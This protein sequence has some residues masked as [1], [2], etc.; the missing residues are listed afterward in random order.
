VALDLAGE[1]FVHG[2][3]P[4][5]FSEDETFDHNLLPRLAAGRTADG[6]T[7]FA[8]IDGRNFARALGMTL[9]QT[10]ALLRELGCTT[11]VNLDGGSSKRMVVRGRAVDLATT[12]VVSGGAPSAEAPV[13]PVF[14]ALL[15]FAVESGG[16][17]RRRRWP[18]SS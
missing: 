1:G 16:R 10:A 15:L 17:G 7:V 9:R 3:P 18:V 13:R 2:A 5:T 6:A 14:S 4:I 8:A 12:E 11:A